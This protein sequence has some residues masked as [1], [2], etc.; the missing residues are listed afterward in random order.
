MFQAQGTAHAK[1]LR[2]EA[3]ENA[4]NRGASGVRRESAAQVTWLY[5]GSSPGAAP[6]ELF[7]FQRQ[8]NSC[9]HYT[10]HKGLPPEVAVINKSWIPALAELC[11]GNLCPRQP[12]VAELQPGWPRAGDQDT[13]VTER[14]QAPA[15]PVDDWSGLPGAY[16]CAR[17]PFQNTSPSPL[18]TLLPAPGVPPAISLP[19]SSCLQPGAGTHLHEPFSWPRARGSP[20]PRV[21]A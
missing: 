15:M 8:Q 19:T 2:L 12:A 14:G 3:G 9:G 21:P 16:P 11:G 5:A 1:T 6:G 10:I 17:L 4:E 18:V 7:N 13:A 20:T